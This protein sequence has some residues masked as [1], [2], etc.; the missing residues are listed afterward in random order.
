MKTKLHGYW[1]LRD[2]TEL[3]HGEIDVTYEDGLYRSE[4]PEF[5]CD[6]PDG[7]EA[8]ELHEDSLNKAFGNENSFYFFTKSEDSSAAYIALEQHFQKMLTEAKISVVMLEGQCEKVAKFKA[9][10]DAM[11]KAMITGM[12][13]R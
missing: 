7:D 9:Q 12:I 11:L 10:K 3:K 2:F 6:V 8:Y 4:T 1:Y 5:P 13:R